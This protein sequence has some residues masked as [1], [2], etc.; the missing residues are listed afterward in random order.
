MAIKFISGVFASLVLLS[1]IAEG[2]NE[3]HHFEMALKECQTLDNIK[4]VDSKRYQCV[5]PKI[6]NVLNKSDV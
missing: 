4:S 3:A 2:Y 6:S 5:A 1:G